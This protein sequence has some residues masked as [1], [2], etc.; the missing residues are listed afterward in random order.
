VLLLLSP[1]YKLIY[2]LSSGLLQLAKTL[3]VILST[4]EGVIECD[5]VILKGYIKSI[6]IAL[7]VKLLI[8]FTC[9]LLAILKAKYSKLISPFKIGFIIVIHVILSFSNKD[10]NINVKEFVLVANKVKV[11]TG[12]D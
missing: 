2:L 11:K 6:N 1:V 5:K 7:I 3:K 8:S 12:R 4:S 10:T 9:N